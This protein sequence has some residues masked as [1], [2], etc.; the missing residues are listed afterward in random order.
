MFSIPIIIVFLFLR[1]YQI[2]D[3]LWFF[4]D[5]GRDLFVIWQWFESNKPPLLGPQ[6]S[7]LPFN[8][9]AVY[10]YL[11]APIHWLTGQS[12]FSSV[13]T[14]LIFY[15]TLFILGIKAYRSDKVMSYAYYAAA[16]LL[17]IHPQVIEQN[18]F[19]WNPSFLPPLIIAAFLSWDSLGKYSTWKIRWL[20]SLSLGL[21]VA[22]S[23]STAPLL[24][25]LA[26]L[27]IWRYRARLRFIGIFISMAVGIGF[28]QIPTIL[29]ELRHNFFLTKLLINGEKLSQGDTSIATKAQQALSNIFPYTAPSLNLALIG[30]LG[31]SLIISLIIYYRRGNKFLLNKLGWS[32]AVLAVTLIITLVIPV[33]LAAHYIFPLLTLMIITIAFFQIHVRIFCLAILS[34]VWLQPDM[35]NHHFAPAF[36]PVRELENCAKQICAQQTEPL[37]VSIQSSH[38]PYH[39]AMEWKFL[40][41]KAGCQVRE[42]DTQ[43]NQAEQMIVIVDHSIYQHGQT[44]YNE[45]TQ[46]GPAQESAR[47]LCSPGLEYINIKKM[48]VIPILFDDN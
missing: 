43:L 21:A 33:G 48:R 38:H 15:L 39:N 14:L 2:Q 41:S 3:S 42:L 26:I 46:F 27:T 7:A 16:W 34:M 24:F 18:R 8:Q 19:V 12:P 20:F 45:L 13:I 25:A 40:L 35:I 28:W 32:T 1:V 17:V 44:A 23:Y 36:H 5:I 10:F 30:I 29:F 11:L 31:L 9:S 47:T 4:N 6:T 22:L 37:F